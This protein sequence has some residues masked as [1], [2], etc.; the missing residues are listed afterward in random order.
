MNDGVVKQGRPMKA[1]VIHRVLR[2]ASL[3]VPMSCMQPAVQAG[4][5]NALPRTLEDAIRRATQQRLE[6]RLATVGVVRAQ[7]GLKAA[8]SGRYPRLGLS[9]DW[10]TIR[11][12]DN[13]TGVTANAQIPGHGP[14]QVDVSS[15]TPRHQLF[16]RL[17]ASYELYAGGRHAAG[18]RQAEFQT[19]SARLHQD[20]TRQ[21]IAFEVSGT[22]LQWRR[23]CI[24]W[25]SAEAA[26]GLSATQRDLAAQRH[27]AGRLSD[28]DWRAARLAHDEKRSTAESRAEAVRTAYAAH[29]ASI[30]DTPGQPASVLSACQFDR[31]VQAEIESLLAQAQPI[32]PTA[33]Q[34]RHGTS[35]AQPQPSEM[36]AHTG[37]TTGEVPGDSA[38]QRR[39]Q[40]DID[41][42][43]EKVEVE[44]SAD[45]PTVSLFAQYGYGARDDRYQDVF[46]AM[47][48]Q[49]A[50]IGIR[51]S[52]TLFD[53][54]LGEARVEAAHAD[55]E[56]RRLERELHEARMKR[57]Q[58]EGAGRQHDADLASTL[59][60]TRLE[61][62][63]ARRQLA[64]EQQRSGRASRLAA[65]ESRVAE[66]QAHDAL[67][68]ADIDRA[69]ARLEWLYADLLAEEPSR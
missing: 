48:R 15:R 8:A 43:R 21:K 64:E 65:E 46:P 61:L 47:R 6:A 35:G 45:R 49:E 16:P 58:E 42:A 29:A 7:A 57:R 27:R 26:L 19:H 11:R 50:L 37:G 54:Y 4:Q 31:T 22:Y 23:R 38:V 32:T 13:Y 41:A 40:H 62:A 30:A 17:E 66:R 18:I 5:E 56:R 28:I 60:R 2:V 25:S 59:A 63:T 24:E 1:C 12:W 52:W 33:A 69:V 36:Q 53:G 44:K 55:L 68:L 51:L 3:V 14:V 10:R 20:I 9:V 39:Y 34:P 67:T